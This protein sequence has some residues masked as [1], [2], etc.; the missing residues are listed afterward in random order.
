M[1]TARTWLSTLTG[2][3][4]LL[5]WSSAKLS[6]ED[7]SLNEVLK[8]GR[9]GILLPAYRYGKAGPAATALLKASIYQGLKARADS[10]DGVG[11]PLFMIIDEAQDVATTDDVA[12][13]SIGRSLGLSMIAATQ[14][15]EGIVSRLGKETTDAWLSIFSNL[16]VLQGGSPNTDD[17]VTRRLGV[18]WKPSVDQ[19]EGWAGLG[20]F[21]RFV[22]MPQ[23]QL[24][25]GHQ[26]RFAQLF[27]ELLR[28]IL[29]CA[30]AFLMGSSPQ[31]RMRIEPFQIIHR[32]PYLANRQPRP[33]HDFPKHR[34]QHFIDDRVQKLGMLESEAGP[35]FRK[36]SET[37]RHAEFPRLHFLA[38]QLAGKSSR[39]AQHKGQRGLVIVFIQGQRRTAGNGGPILDLQHQRFIPL[40][41]GEQPQLL[42]PYPKFLLEQH[43]RQHFLPKSKHQ[44]LLV[45]AISL[46]KYLA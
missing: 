46:F 41:I 13:L 37:H 8:G 36:I 3:P 44:L 42:T 1:I 35:D 6:E 5:K 20:L 23:G 25:S 10:K 26:D 45:L 21:L 19:V 34:L 16:V 18:S 40:P 31:C 39:L 12:M 43:G 28:H 32:N 2:H 7:Y 11:R 9:V 27:I 4:D 14:G 38:A 24:R 22:N 15:I 30:P 17:L 33:S 29:H